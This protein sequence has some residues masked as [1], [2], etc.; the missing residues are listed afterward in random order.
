M[1]SM[2]FDPMEDED[3]ERPPEPRGLH[4]QGGGP[5]RLLLLLAVLGG[6]VLLAAAWY[7]TR[8]PAP[9]PATAHNAPL[10][11]ESPQPAPPAAVSE[12]LPA[13]RPAV[14]LPALGESDAFV[15]E[16]LADLSSGS[17]LGDWLNAADE[18]VKR[19]VRATLAVAAGRSPRAAL[20]FLPL[21]GK[22]TTLERNGRTYLDPASYHRYD[23]IGAAFAALDDRRIAQLAALVRDLRPLVSEAFAEE[24]FPGTTFDETLAAAS[25]QLSATP[26][27]DRE[28]ELVAG[29]SGNFRFADPKLESLSAAQKHLLRMGPANAALVQA[30]LAALVRA[31]AEER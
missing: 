8:T 20:G 27:L 14:E 1:H 31:L 21:A 24:A 16:R 19:G 11:S 4:D 18:I 29:E 5:S 9:P 6:G 25:Q 22:F 10:T 17:G 28:I 15:R 26:R 13:A 30:K 7:F 12:A 3:P 2:E 23:A